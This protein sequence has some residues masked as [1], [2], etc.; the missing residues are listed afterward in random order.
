MQSYQA[1]ID[2]TDATL[3]TLDEAKIHLRVTHDADDAYITGIIKSAYLYAENY[4][5][6][7]VLP[8]ETGEA[9]TAGLVDFNF[10]RPIYL[11][12]G[13]YYTN[14]SNEIIGAKG[15]NE[16]PISAQVVLDQ[17]RAHPI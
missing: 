12:I 6:T 13:S 5:N 14:R 1:D 17:Y 3:I 9:S 4:C 16:L 7:I 10:N 11:L 8:R 2:W 15:I